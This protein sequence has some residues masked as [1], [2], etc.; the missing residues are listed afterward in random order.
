MGPQSWGVSA[1]QVILP[2]LV[3][4]KQ[5]HSGVYYDGAIYAAE[6]AAYRES[7]DIRY[8]YVLE[9][10]DVAGITGPEDAMSRTWT[11]MQPFQ[12][13]CKES[14]IQAFNGDLYY[15]G[16]AGTLTDSLFLE[17]YNLESETSIVYNSTFIRSNSRT[18]SFISDGR[19]TV[20]GGHDRVPPRNESEPAASTESAMLTDLSKFEGIDAN[21]VDDVGHYLN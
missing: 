16:D 14:S 12:T 9:K 11:I 3:E 17:V 13:H 4:G 20:I 7:E 8:R 15:F 19:F 6:S 10:L 18:A 5:A 1:N 21:I 2:D